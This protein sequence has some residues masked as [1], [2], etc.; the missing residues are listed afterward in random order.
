MLLSGSMLLAGACT[1]P[2]SETAPQ[3][4]GSRL[5]GHVQVL[6]RRLVLA[7]P[8]GDVA[9]TTISSFTSELGVKV[10][11]VPRRLDTVTDV[12]QTDVALIDDVTLAGLIQANLVEKIDRGLVSNA[13]LLL[14]P[15]DN[16]SYDRGGRHSV[17]K[18]YVTVGFAVS[19][20][21]VPVPPSSWSGFFHL[22]GA[23][24][25]R[26]SVPPDRDVVIGA[27]LTAAGH[28]WNS[29]SSSD[30]ADGADIL[31]PLREDLV[32]G[33]SMV[34]SRLP[35]PLVAALCFGEGFATPTAGI[36]FVVPRDG[37]MVRAR[38][39]CIPPFAPDPVSAH[40]WLNHTLDPAVAAAETR[41]THRAT[42]VGPA[43]Y[44][45]P[46]SLLANE[47]I[48]PPALPPVP[49]TFANVTPAGA[50][51]RADLWQEFTATRRR[52]PAPR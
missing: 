10:T 21:A 8:P 14:P 49:L 22:A 3:R 33:G 2:G 9:P 48:F 36:R 20:L 18:D 45:L 39:Y 42:P 24:P 32:V 47:A 40:A 4:F 1:R 19:T 16:P 12:G 6:D 26:V 34:R 35:A 29:S 50:A 30:M 11:V 31:L 23:L 37:T 44:Q 51:L 52:R 7:L 27:A 13:K 28:D 38:C 25:G 46:A 41:Y 5:A 17:P 43:V 15:F